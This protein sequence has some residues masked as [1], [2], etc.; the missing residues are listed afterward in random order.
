MSSR[1]SG[2][3]SAIPAAL[4]ELEAYTHS[5]DLAQALAREALELRYASSVRARRAGVSMAR[6]AGVLG[7]SRQAI[8]AAMEAR[9][10]A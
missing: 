2:N 5:A 3:S 4:A 10:D 1:P 9:G 7:I 8:S 6:V